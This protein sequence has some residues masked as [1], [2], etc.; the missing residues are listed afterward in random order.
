MNQIF[1]IAAL[2]FFRSILF[3]DAAICRQASFRRKH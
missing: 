2:P 1:A 3:V